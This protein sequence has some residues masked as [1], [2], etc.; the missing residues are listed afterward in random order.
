[1]QLNLTAEEADMLKEI[2]ASYLSDLRM[3]IADTDSMD[4][5]EELKKR[6]VLL[7]RLIADIGKS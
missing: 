6:E 3:E 2:L 1:M 7:K 4:F 5:R